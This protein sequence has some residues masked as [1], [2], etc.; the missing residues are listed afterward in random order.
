MREK[1]H[2]RPREGH[3]SIPA[4]VRGAPGVGQQRLCARQL[5]LRHQGLRERQP[6]LETRA[7]RHGR[8][9][10]AFA[11]HG[12]LE[13]VGL[14]GGAHE[15]VDVDVA[16]RIQCE[17]RRQTGVGGSSPPRR[18]ELGREPPRGEPP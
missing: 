2:A 1:E 8:A 6:G 12:I 16:A 14:L 10:E 7:R 11:R 18:G 15:G 4:R 3:A 17:R 9:R 13:G 5:T